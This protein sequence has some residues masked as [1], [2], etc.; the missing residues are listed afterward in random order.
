MLAACPKLHT[1]A[2]CSP[3]V[4]PWGALASF[5]EPPVE[6]MHAQL[7]AHMTA[8]ATTAAPVQRLR[9]AFLDTLI[10][11]AAVDRLRALQNECPAAAM[12]PA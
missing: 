3:F 12:S 5:G 9:S 4:E 2:R 1:L 7:S 8:R 10:P 6:G 11:L